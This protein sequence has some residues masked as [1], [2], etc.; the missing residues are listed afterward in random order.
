MADH[1]ESWREF[2]VMAG[3]AA[4]ILTGLVFVA[5]SLYAKA[6]MSHALYRDRA[7]QVCNRSQPN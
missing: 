1:A 7:I 4:A 2:Y 6:I 5:L 3:G